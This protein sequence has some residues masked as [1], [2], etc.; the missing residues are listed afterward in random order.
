MILSKRMQ[1]VVNLL[2]KGLPVADVGCDHGFVSIYLVE[3][4]MS[5]RVIAMDVNQGPLSRAKKHIEEH[6]L[7]EKIELRL[8]DGLLAVKENEID[9]AIIAGMG[10]RLVLKILTDSLDL[11][12]RMQCLVLQPQSDIDFVRHTLCELGFSF[13]KEDMVEEDGKY[14]PSFLVAYTGRDGSKLQR[15]EEYFGPILLKEKNEV[16]KAY[17]NREL[18]KYT[19]IEK[20][21]TEPGNGNTT[22]MERIQLIE[23][24]FN[25]FA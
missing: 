21:I 3:N 18:A 5:E 10:G 13:L 22:V 12:K 24:A 19:E 23:E 14:Y 15:V 11:V 1:M 20:Q 6:H 17:L 25:Y 8:S 16:L 4:N 9:A 7:Q 2:P